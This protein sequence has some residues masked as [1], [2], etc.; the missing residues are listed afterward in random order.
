M[1]YFEMRCKPLQ[2]NWHPF[3]TPFVL[4]SLVSQSSYSNRKSKVVAASKKHK[5]ASL[6]CI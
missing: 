6:S 2:V 4:G 3:F 5:E 1:S